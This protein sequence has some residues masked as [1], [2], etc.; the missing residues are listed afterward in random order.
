[1]DKNSVL[2]VHCHMLNVQYLATE[3]AAITW[4]IICGNYPRKK[5]EKAVGER[6]L[7]A[8]KLDKAEGLPELLAWAARLIKVAKG[9]C[10]E[11]YDYMSK[12]FSKSLIGK[13]RALYCAPLMMD[14]Y[15][16]LDNNKSYG[17][18][19]PSIGK[20]N[21]E[22]TTCLHGLDS[23]KTVKDYDAHLDKL[24]KLFQKAYLKN[25]TAE[26]TLTHDNTLDEIF[27]KVRDDFHADFRNSQRRTVHS[28]L[29]DNVEMS[30][31]Y[32]KQIEE[33]TKLKNDLGNAIMP[34]LAVDPRR[35][36]VMNLVK[37]LVDRTKG[38]FSG[39][40]LYP[41]LGYLPTD[42]ALCEIFDYCLTKN[43][44]V[45]AHCS[46]SEVKNFRKLNYV[47]ST[48]KGVYPKTVSTPKDIFYADPQNWTYV[49]DK[50][51]GLHLDLAHFGGSEQFA[52]GDDAWMNKTI[53]MMKNYSALYTDLS[54]YFQSGLMDKVLVRAQSA[55]VSDRIM[56]GTD[57][58]IVMLEKD[59]GKLSNYYSNSGPYDQ[60]Y[61]QSYAMKFLG[62]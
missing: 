28:S 48:V 50:W 62:M 54:Y 39:V 33:I 17:V 58:T 7:S 19:L 20:N 16:C 34:F 44:P 6:T 22:R 42:P 56:F 45:I 3:I 30:P 36:G 52:Q 5:A 1:M 29:Y 13:D 53:E 15:Y 26:K 23:E 27:N 59:L 9:S 31:G 24:K 11:N 37:S 35:Q 61:H 21:F 2:D 51:K 55:G 32:K 4:N 41:P 25:S 10:R 12:E 14:I 18:S 8:T 47:Q 38:P 40:K 49:L 46:P 57:Y 60:D 43:I